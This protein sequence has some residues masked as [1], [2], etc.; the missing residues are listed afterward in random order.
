VAEWEEK[1][2]VQQWDANFGQL[3]DAAEFFGLPGKPPF[4]VGVGGMNFIS[5]SLLKEAESMAHRHPS[6][7][8]T[9]RGGERVESMSRDEAGRW[10]L[11]GKTGEAAFHDSTEAVA[12]AQAKKPLAAQGFDAIV[13]TDLSSSFG[14]WHRASAGVPQSFAD[15]VAARAGA[16]VP[17]FTTM[18]AFATPLCI[19]LDAMAIEDDCLWF[20]ARSGSKGLANGGGEEIECWTLVA[21]PEWSM[22]LIKETPMQDAK[23]GAFLPQAPDYLTTVPAPQMEAAFLAVLQKRGLLTT[24]PPK[25]LYR[26]AQRWG[27]AMPA[28]RQPTG[29]P[30]QER[31][32]GVEY[33]SAGL[34]EAGSLAPTR[35]LDDGL[36]FLHDEGLMLFQ[37]GDMVSAHTPGFEGAA[38]SGLGL[39]RRIAEVAAARAAPRACAGPV[40]S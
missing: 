24:K 6:F 9:L 21:T 12:Q 26:N 40:F 14:A 3:G 33:D 30:T 36:P 10:L 22:R 11:W 16:R 29:S 37:A 38:L 39:A 31:I 1:G 18:L 13:L 28:L 27:S 2:Y 17:L 35:A 20:A 15:R 7:E 4:F 25:R 5:G 19:E 32:S 34:R 8:F 23:T